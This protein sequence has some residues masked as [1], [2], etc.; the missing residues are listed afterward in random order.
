MCGTESPSSSSTTDIYTEP[1]G[2][3]CDANCTYSFKLRLRRLS[4][5]HLQGA[6]KAG[7]P[8]W[9]VLLA[10]C[11]FPRSWL[12]ISQDWD[13]KIIKI[14]FTC[15]WFQHPELQRSKGSRG[16]GAVLPKACLS[17]G[18]GPSLSF[19]RPSSAQMDEW[20]LSVYF[21][22][23]SDPPSF[24]CLPGQM[25]VWVNW[26]LRWFQVTQSVGPGIRYWFLFSPLEGSK[27]WSQ[28]Y[29]IE[30]RQNFISLWVCTVYKD[31]IAFVL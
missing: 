12:E 28:G 21:I 23:V 6:V 1:P 22:S 7:I 8:G 15:L 13:E 5:T 30:T 16:S 3:L 20:C 27:C 11:C 31:F 26:L 18:G 19:S 24:A 2:Y 14:R 9:I 10:L 29:C 4:P 25:F 17:T